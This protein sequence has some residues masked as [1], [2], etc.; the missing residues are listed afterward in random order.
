MKKYVRLFNEGIRIKKEPSLDD[1][2]IQLQVYLKDKADKTADNFADAII[3]W[4]KKKK[5]VYAMD[6]KVN[7]PYDL[8]TFLYDDTKNKNYTLAKVDIKREYAKDLEKWLR[9]SGSSFLKK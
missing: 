5:I 1:E 8:D 2:F 3:A 7:Q 6:T 4:A 9:T